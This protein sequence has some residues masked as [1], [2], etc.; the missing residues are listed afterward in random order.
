LVE[1]SHQTIQSLQGIRP[2]HVF[3][4]HGYIQAKISTCLTQI[5]AISKKVF[6]W[7]N[8]IPILNETI[9]ILL[10]GTILIIGSFILAKSPSAGLPS[11][12]TY[13][14]LTYRLASRLQNAMGYLGAVAVHAGSLKRLNQ[15]LR[16]QD[17]EFMPVKGDL[18]TGLSSSIEFKNVSLTYSNISTAALQDLSFQIKRGAVTAFVGFSGA[19]KSSVLD[20][21]LRLFEPTKGS[22]VVDSKDLRDYSLE[23]WRERLGVVSQDTYVFNDT[24]EENIRFG[25][26]GATHE[27]IINAAQAAGAHEFIAQMPQSYQTV[28]GERGYRLSGGERQ[29]VALARALLRNPDILIL[30]EATSSLDSHTERLIQEF[31]EKFHQNKTIVLVAHRLSTV[32]KADQ[33]IVLENGQVIESGK[34]DDLIRKNGRYSYLWRLQSEEQKATVLV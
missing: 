3:H 4:R 24:I 17:K 13:L 10:V 12:L 31:L 8:F 26:L 18:F 25:F 7:N 1:F 28:V 22:V 2:I 16:T 14:A 34:H 30:D 33:I 6:L 21:L 5:A 29:R 27:E 19:G 9:N 11:L 32:M 23:S 20:V 15:I